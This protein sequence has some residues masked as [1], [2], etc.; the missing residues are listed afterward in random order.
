MRVLYSFNKIGS[1]AKCWESE[2]RAASD[3][4]ASFIAFNHGA[5]LDPL[6]YDDS[7]KLDKLYQAKD[8][9]LLQMYSAV[10][11]YISDHRID[12]LFVT[13]CPPYHPDFLRRLSPFKVLYSTDDP[14]ATYMRT[15]PYL[16]AYQHVMFCAQGYSADMDL[17]D[18]MRY[19][20]MVN[21]TWLP[22][23]VM[24]YERDAAQTEDSIVNHQR[25]IDV[26]YVGKFWRQKLDLLFEVKK[27]LRKELRI[28]GVFSVKHNVYVNCRYGFPGWVRPVSFEER[29]QL[30]QRSKI[31]INI[32]YNEYALGNQRMYHLPANGVM[33]LC[34]CERYVGRIMRDGEEVIS[35]NTVDDLVDKVRYFLRHPDERRAIAINGYRKVQRDYCFSTVVRRMAEVIRLRMQEVDWRKQAAYSY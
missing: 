6:L 33:Q 15:I 10:E 20:G 9:R 2:I 4:D 16:H 13:N 24:N 32:H 14:P 5:Y 11:R 1:E 19:C 27:R 17:A 28:Y 8:K 35:Y 3:Q 25:D 22:L 30:Y 23:G 21:A 31:G 26:I 29:V 18:K 34:D 12:V 7:V